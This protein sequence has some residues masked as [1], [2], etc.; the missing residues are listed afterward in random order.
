[1]KILIADD[2][3]YVRIELLAL[4]EDLIPSAS[5]KEVENGT[6][7]DRELAEEHY[8]LVFLDIRMPGASGLEILEKHFK[9]LRDTVFIIVSGYS[10]FEYARKALRLNVTEYLLKPVDRKELSDV[11]SRVIPLVEVHRTEEA[12]NSSRLIRDAETIIYKRY[13]EAI[14]VAQIADELHVSPNYLSSQFRKQKGMT[15]TSYM[16]DLRLKTATEMLKLPGANIRSISESLGYQ[17]SRHFARIFKEKFD[18]TPSEY[19]EK[20]RV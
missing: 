6:E 1:M 17:S 13:K 5:V 3:Q 10:D 12:D 16:T 4:L 15:L 11:L 18:C 14:G 19:M 8:S 9:R 20:S 2:E 7:L